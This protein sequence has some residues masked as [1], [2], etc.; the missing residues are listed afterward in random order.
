MSS[1]L[2]DF[3][4]EASGGIAAW[5][6]AREIVVTG[7]LGGLVL[8]L[9][10]EFDDDPVREIRIATDRPYVV[11]IGYPSAGRRGV[12]TG[13]EVRIESADGSQVLQRRQNPRSYFFK[14][15]ANLRRKLYWD[16]LDVAYFTGYAVWNYFLTPYLLT[17]QGVEAE[18][19]EP[20][21]LGRRR[22]VAH[23]PEGFHT[24]SREQ[25]FT[26]G[27]DGLLDHFHYV[28][29][30]MGKWAKVI[31][32]CE[33][34]KSFA[35]DN[36]GAKISFSTVRRAAFEEDRFLLRLRMKILK[37]SFGMWGDIS[38]IQVV[39]DPSLD[40]DQSKRD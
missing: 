29:D 21:E 16:D 12:F 13:D 19:I 37:K 31:H 33:S 8:R 3:A 10:S 27:N 35:E 7:Q 26:F 1:S 14:F 2:L 18:E 4:L 30:I 11:V 20:D 28:F 25:I 15:P 17:F 39:T 38:T 6:A 9:H 5:Q 40:F 36:E 22:L 32:Y 24:H 34:Y 23:F